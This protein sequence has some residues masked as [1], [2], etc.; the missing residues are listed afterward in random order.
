[1]TKGF[2]DGVWFAIQTLV[3]TPGFDQPGIARDIARE[4]GLTAK[5][6]RRLQKLSGYETRKMNKFIKENFEE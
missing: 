2:N 6:M 1:M 3:A 5:E 4:A